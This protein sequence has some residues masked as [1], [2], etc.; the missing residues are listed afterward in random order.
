ML[1][2]DLSWK[3][4]AVIGHWLLCL[5][6]LPF[7]PISMV[8]LLLKGAVCPPISL[9]CQ[10]ILSSTGLVG[11]ASIR[12]MCVC[13]TGFIQGGNW[14]GGTGLISWGPPFI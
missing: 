2:L 8:S 10:I 11:G 4:V 6:G 12:V 13:I 9:W 5:V 3:P 1:F 14:I 7:F